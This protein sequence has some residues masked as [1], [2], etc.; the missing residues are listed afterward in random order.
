MRDL[1]SYELRVLRDR[2]VRQEFPKHE[3]P[4]RVVALRDHYPVLALLARQWVQDPGDST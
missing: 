2:Y 3:Y 1:Y 4:E